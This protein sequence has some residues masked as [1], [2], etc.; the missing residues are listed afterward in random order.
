M[1]GFLGDDGYAKLFPQS[2][3]AECL[4]WSKVRAEVFDFLAGAQNQDGSWTGGAN[5]GPV[6]TT[7]LYS[8]VLQ[9]DREILPLYQR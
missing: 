2:R 5:I 8:T 7:A 9:L 1:T 6:Y 4:R 3:E